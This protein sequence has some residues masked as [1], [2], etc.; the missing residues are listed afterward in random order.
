MTSHLI[1]SAAVA[2]SCVA[3]NASAVVAQSGKEYGKP[4]TL[5][6]KT[7]ISA[8]LK[9]P[10]RYDGKRVQVE[11]VI[12]EV[13]EKRGCWIRIASDREFESIRFKVD[14][15]IITFPMEAKG[16]M[17]TAEGVVSV[18]TLT[19]EQAIEQARE[20]A[21][22]RGA[23]FDPTTIKGPVTDIELTGDGARVK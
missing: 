8:I 19:R 13:C 23:K 3:L 2:L 17:V 1:R 6:E 22:E 5:N 7:A 11:G 14:D 18:K 20:T 9:D 10:K 15:G 4:L 21:K 16:R 12:V